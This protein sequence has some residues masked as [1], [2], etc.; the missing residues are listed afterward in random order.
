MA[1]AQPGTSQNLSASL[2][3]ASIALTSDAG[4]RAARGT[5]GSRTRTSE[6]SRERFMPILR[7]RVFYSF[8]PGGEGVVPV[9]SSHRQ[10]ALSRD[11]HGSRAA[12]AAHHEG[13][14]ITGADRMRQGEQ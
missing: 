1:T 14:Q 2:T 3:T 11:L 13:V 6:A 5:A 7:R 8:P 9:A 12:L 10:V 4:S